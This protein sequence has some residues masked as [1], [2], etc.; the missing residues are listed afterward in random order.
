[1]LT[2][3]AA[4]EIAVVSG[5]CLRAFLHR[6]VERIV[7]ERHSLGTDRHADHLVTPPDLQNT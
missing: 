6:W 5:F 7:V 3:A 1:V 4:K 2:T